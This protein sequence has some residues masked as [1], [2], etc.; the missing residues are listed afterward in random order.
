M[1]IASICEAVTLVLWR[2]FSEN[3]QLGGPNLYWIMFDPTGLR[4]DLGKLFLLNSKYFP[5]FIK[6]DGS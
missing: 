1:P 6:K 3:L 2:S 4:E 5:F